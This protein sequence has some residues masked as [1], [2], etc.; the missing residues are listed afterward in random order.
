MI[1]YQVQRIQSSV[2]LN[3][4]GKRE[5]ADYSSASQQ[6]TPKNGPASGTSR[7]EEEED[8]DERPMKKLK[9]THPR[10]AI[11]IKPCDYAL[12]AFRANG[13][14]IDDARTRLA[15]TFPPTPC[16]NVSLTNAYKAEVLEA[17]RKGDLTKL[18]D[19]DESK[20]LNVNACNRW[21][22][23]LLHLA[24]RRS[25]T[26]VVEF[27]LNKGANAHIRDDYHRTPLHDA[28]WTTEPNFELVDLLLKHGATYQVLMQD[29][30]GF[31]PFDYVRQEHWGQW[32][33]FLWERKSILKVEDKETKGLP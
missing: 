27:L 23:S 9:R 25:H 14:S 18:K 10:H 29:V 11:V 8:Q 15:S 13:V 6:V 32:L 22:D 1:G 20:T 33:R 31:T 4:D 5:E 17:I 28:A 30:R 19:L 3:E 12:A 7:R 21:G 16:T 2:A 26:K 24:C